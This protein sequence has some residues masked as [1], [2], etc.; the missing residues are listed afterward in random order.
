MKKLLLLSLMVIGFLSLGACQMIEERQM[1]EQERRFHDVLE[2]LQENH[3]KQLAEG[4]FWDGAI[5]G[6][7][8]ALEDPYSRYFS[9]EEYEQY[10]QSLGESFVGVGVTIEN[11][12]DQVLVT[13]VWSESPAERAGIRAG[14]IITHVDGEDY[15]EQGFLAIVGAVQGRVDTEVELGVSRVGVSE[16]LFMT[17][18]REEIPNPSVEHHLIEEDGQTLGYIK[19]NSFGSET[20]DIFKDVLDDFEGNRLDGLIIDLRNNGGGNLQ[21]VLTL[22]QIFLIKDDTPLFSTES[23]FRGQFMVQ[24]YHGNREVGRPYEV[25]TLINGHSASA[26]EVFASAMKQKGSYELIG[27]PT[28]GKGTMQTS[29]S[30]RNLGDDELHVS[31]GIWRT[32]NGTWVNNRGGDQKHVF[33]TIEVEQN[34]YFNAHNIYVKAGDA[35]TFDMVDPQVAHAQVIL[36]ALGY[37]TIRDDSYFDTE[38]VEAV[39]AF[40]ADHDLA[41]SG[42]IDAE[43]AAMLS[44]QLIA[45]R[46]DLANDHQ[47]QAAKDFF[48]NED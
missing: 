46:N 20:A 21:T 14:D 45:F 19:V 5:Q 42:E 6:L 35:L 23:Y 7:F 27:T 29:H 25:V 11:V 44:E 28:F 1:S 12:S 40:Q 2:H 37:G 17:M 31:T 39:Q 34:P 33:P 9:Q 18:V 43:T 24:E 41:T 15:S 30:T 13:K 26:S 16:T 8:D 22:M 47:Y 38:T 48:F 10:R 36:N 32:S 3:Y 4:V